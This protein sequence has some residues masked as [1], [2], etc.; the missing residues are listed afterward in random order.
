MKTAG[1]SRRLIGCQ[2]G[3]PAGPFFNP[4][5]VQLNGGWLNFSGEDCPHFKGIREIMENYDAD[6]GFVMK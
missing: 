4:L 5:D 6:V 1:T 2:A 3:N